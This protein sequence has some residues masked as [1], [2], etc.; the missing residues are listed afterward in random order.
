MENEYTPNQDKSFYV[1][2]AINE[3]GPKKL[4]VSA[5]EDN[6]FSVYQHGQFLCKIERKDDDDEEGEVWEVLEGNITRGIARAI[7]REISRVVG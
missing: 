4:K 5:V 3:E 6:R 7:G 1:E 2:A